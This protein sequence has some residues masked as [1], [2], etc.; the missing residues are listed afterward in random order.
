MPRIFLR[1]NFDDSDYTSD[2]DDWGM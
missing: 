1:E 2:S